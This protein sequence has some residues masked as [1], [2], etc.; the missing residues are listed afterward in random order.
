MVCGKRGAGRKGKRKDT[1]AG[2]GDAVYK[3]RRKQF[4]KEPLARL[5]VAF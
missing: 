1:P 5:A 4:E 2:Q 3:C